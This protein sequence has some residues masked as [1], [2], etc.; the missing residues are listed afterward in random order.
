MGWAVCSGRNKDETCPLPILG[1]SVLGGYL[2]DGF[3]GLIDNTI[4][5][6]TT[7]PRISLAPLLMRHGA[8]LAAAIRF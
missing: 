6:S 3:D 2:G 7:K 8:G 4:Y 5:R 1:L